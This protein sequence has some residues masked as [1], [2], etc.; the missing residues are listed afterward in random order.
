MEDGP[1]IFRQDFTCPALLV[2][3][4]VPPSTFRVRGCHPLRPTFPDR[5]TKSTAKTCKALPI[6]LATTLGISV[7]FFSSGYLDVSVRR[8]RLNILCIQIKILLAEW[9]SPFGH[10][11]IKASLPAPRRFSQACASFI[12]CDRQGIHHMHLVA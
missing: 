10:R 6:S 7:D 4:L 11:R 9:V 8:V 1:P 2:A 5:S 3:S 12:A